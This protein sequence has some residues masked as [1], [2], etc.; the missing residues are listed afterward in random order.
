MGEKLLKP[1]RRSFLVLYIVCV[2]TLGALALHAQ[3]RAQDNWTTDAIKSLEIR[4]EADEKSSTQNTDKLDSLERRLSK[5][6]E[7]NDSNGKLLIGMLVSIIM[8]MFEGLF[9][10]IRVRRVEKISGTATD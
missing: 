1:I 7:Q 6:E 4:M 3:Q 10:M 9:R 5:I 2:L 8:I